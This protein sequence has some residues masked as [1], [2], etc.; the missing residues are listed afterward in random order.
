MIVGR[1]AVDTLVCDRN[2]DLARKA[3]CAKEYRMP[4]APP[5]HRRDVLMS[6]T[7]KV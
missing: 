2:D 4:D 3:S 1:G 5:C 7:D 6:K